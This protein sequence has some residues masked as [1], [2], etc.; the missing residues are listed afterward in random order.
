MRAMRAVRSIAPRGSLFMRASRLEWSRGEWL[1]AVAPWARAW[2]GCLLRLGGLPPHPSLLE[3]VLPAWPAVLSPEAAAQRHPRE[4]GRRALV[5]RRCLRLRLFGRLAE[6]AWR[7]SAPV[8]GGAVPPAAAS[9]RC[10]PSRRPRQRRPAL[11]GGLHE[12]IP[13]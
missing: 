4:T 5:P 10:H 13:A 1:P 8:S 6:R 7:S 2:E 9:W 12:T 3:R 11:R